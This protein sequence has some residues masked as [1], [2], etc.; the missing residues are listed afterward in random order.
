[1]R[2]AP[3]AA[4]E[5]LELA[6][7]L[8]GGAELR[9]RAAEHHFDAGDTRRAQA[10][11]EEAIAAFP[12]GESRA[13]ALLLLGETRYHDDSFPEARPLLEQARAEAVGN[14]RLLVMIDLS[15]PSAVQPRP[16][17]RRGSGGVVSARPCGALRRLGAPCSSL[18]VSTI[19]DFSLGRGLDES[20]LHR[21]LEL[22]DPDRRTGAEFYPSLIASFVFLWSG[23]FDESRAHL[24]AVCAQ[25][26][27]RGEDHAFAW[28]RFTGV[29]LESWSGDLAAASRAADEASEGLLLL[30]TGNGK[31]LA[32]TA[33]AQVDACAGRAEAARGGCRGALAL[34]EDAGWQTWSWFPRVTLGF[35]E[36]SVDGYEAAA[37]ALE[38]LAA[39]GISTGLP[40]PAPAGM[41][42]AGDAAEAFV[43]VGRL[44]EAET[45]VSLLEQRGEALDRPWAIAVGA[46][47]RGLLLSATGDVGAA[48]AALERALR[49]HEALPMP[50]ER[51]RSLLVLGRIRRR[52][53][54]RRASKTA[55]DEA[56]EIFEGVG[57][58]LWADQASAEIA[59]LGLRPSAADGLTPSEERVA[60]LVAEGR[61]NREVAASLIVSPKTVEASLAR[62]YR[63]LGIRSRAELGALMAERDATPDR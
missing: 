17:A 22:G 38:P 14:E 43:A 61:T 53:R 5:L 8:G 47:C 16:D 37:A 15:S 13:E 28:A 9:V 32:L 55:L 42:F 31:A 26:A 35:L 29:W 60:R 19:V 11:L 50:I 63:K 12:A 40:D 20:R 25:Y 4:A 57:S 6:L 44:E 1:M 36:L 59:C 27:A 49:A 62:A 3:D 7:G 21:A 33:R 34:F 39:M 54:K 10:L 48:E 58:R 24:S 30:E 52:L 46:R 18:A 56:L 51:G 45:L 23:R 41:L 2:G